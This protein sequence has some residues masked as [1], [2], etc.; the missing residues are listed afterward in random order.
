MLIEVVDDVEVDSAN[1]PQDNYARVA[2]VVILT[3]GNQV[4]SELCL[5]FSCKSVS[6]FD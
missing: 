6:D 3:L 5:N 2:H 1:M 4:E